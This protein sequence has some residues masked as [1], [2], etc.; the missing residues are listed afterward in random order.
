[1]EA[2]GF[3]APSKASQCTNSNGV[4]SDYEIRQLIKDK[5]LTPTLVDEAMV[6]YVS[7]DD[8]WI[9]YHDEV[10]IGMQIEFAISKCLGGTTIWAIDYDSRNSNSG[11]SIGKGL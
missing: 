8:Q 11:E 7:W 3:N 4:M 6:K 10:M 5:S 1:M 9:V 2:C